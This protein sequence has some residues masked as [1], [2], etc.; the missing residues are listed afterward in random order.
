MDFTELVLVGVV[1]DLSEEVEARPHADAIAFQVGGSEDI[2]ALEEYNGELPIIATNWSFEEKEQ[3]GRDRNISNIESVP[4]IES[5]EAVEVDYESIS[6]D[7]N[8][9][10]A[11]LKADID[12]IVS[13][14]NYSET[15]ELET[16]LSI[17]EVGAKYG[18]VVYIETMAETPDDA[19]TLLTTI[20][21]ATENGIKIGGASLGEIGRHTRVVAPSYGSKLAYASIDEDSEGADL[22][23]FSLSNLAELIQESEEPSTP[24]SLHDSITN[25][26][27]T[28]E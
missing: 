16:L 7:N 5:V 24:T 25:P 14:R 9:L 6:S 22:G 26:M 1:D 18:D 2:A 10:E 12:I 20:Y 27:V 3:E 8:S 23:Q 17:I 28:D 13:Y 19:L 15:P 4:G 11:V 21:A